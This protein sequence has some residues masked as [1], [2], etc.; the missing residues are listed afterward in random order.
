MFLRGLLASEERRRVRA[1]RVVRPYE[2]QRFALRDV[3]DAVPYEQA[4]IIPAAP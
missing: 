2:R 4:V 3:G 1:N